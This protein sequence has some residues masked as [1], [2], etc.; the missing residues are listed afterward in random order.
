M[1]FSQAVYFNGGMCVCYLSTVKEIISPTLPKYCD[2]SLHLPVIA[3]NTFT[4][5]S[6]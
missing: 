4:N 6:V 3:L 1:P 2:F 5:E